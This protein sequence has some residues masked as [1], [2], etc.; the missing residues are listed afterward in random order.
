[1]K[2]HVFLDIHFTGCSYFHTIDTRM[3][4]VDE[5]STDTYTAFQRLGGG[6]IINHLLQLINHI[7]H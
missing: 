1:M 4:H 2:R 7:V 3:A 6:E 5:L